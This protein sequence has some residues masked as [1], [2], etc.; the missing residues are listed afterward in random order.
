MAEREIELPHIGDFDSVEVIELLVKVGDRVVAEQSLLVLES[1]KATMEIPSPVAGVV[2]KL[3][4]GV[5]DAVREGTP[6][7]VL[8]VDGASGERRAG[9]SRS[10]GAARSRRGGATGSHHDARC[11]ERRRTLFRRPGAVHGG[12][13]P[14][15]RAR[16]SVRAAARAR[17][18]RRPR[19]RPG[20]RAQ[21]S[22]PGRGRAGLREGAHRTGRWRRV[23]SRSPASTSQRRSTSTSPS[24]DPIESEAAES[25]AARRGGEPAPQLGHRPARHA[26][27]RRRRHRAR[28]PSARTIAPRRE[29]RGTKL[30]FLPF[31][32]KAAVKALQEFPHFNA[33]LDRSGE[34]LIVKRYFHIGVA[35]DTEHGLVVPVV[36]DA[37]R[38]GL[39]RDSRPSCRNSPRRRARGGCG[40]SSCRA[41]TFSISSLGGIGG[42]R[43]TPIVNHPEVAILGVSRMEWRPVWQDGA[44][45]PRRILPLSLSYDHRVID[46]ADGARFTGRLA[47][48][49]ADLRRI[50]L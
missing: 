11:M 28:E 8:D 20:P 5:G 4:V 42:T 25:R 2:R 18:R 13:A 49:L 12:C 46:G 29:A 48:L 17:T 10:R 26:V 40:P 24:S 39:L 27:R 45:V 19:A 35:V 50:L 41:A 15:G 16:R 21:G 7:A 44:F 22:H 30:T 3:L 1:D 32:V 31:L 37:D 47:A 36:R 43:F 14:S 9:G 34:N 38:K 23:A 6:I 33:S